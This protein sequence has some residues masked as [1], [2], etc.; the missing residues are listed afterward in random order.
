MNYFIINKMTEIHSVCI[1]YAMYQWLV[2]SEFPSLESTDT[3]KK[4]LVYLNVY[5]IHIRI[6]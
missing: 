3:V 5:H 1:L 2:L 6:P 4:V